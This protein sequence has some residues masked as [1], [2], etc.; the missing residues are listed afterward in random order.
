MTAI[1]RYSCIKCKSYSKG[2]ADICGKVNVEY[3]RV[4]GTKAGRLGKNVVPMASLKV[5]RQ[6][7]IDATIASIKDIEGLH[8]SGVKSLLNQ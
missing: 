1:I 2:K 4:L 7:V 6:C 8:T 3:A 5:M